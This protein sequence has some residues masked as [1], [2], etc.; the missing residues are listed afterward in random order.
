MKRMK[1]VSNLSGVQVFWKNVYYLLFPPFQNDLLI[2]QNVRIKA[3]ITLF[4]IISKYFKEVV[5]H[6]LNLQEQKCLIL[7]NQK[8]ILG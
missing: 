4:Q 6:S 1:D 8:I 3:K 5:I 7:S 2:V